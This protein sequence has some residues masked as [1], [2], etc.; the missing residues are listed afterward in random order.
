MH[1]VAIAWVF[2]VGLAA[3]V[4]ATSAQGSLLGALATLVFY[5]VV[6]LTVVL[7]V[8]GTP[9]R[10]RARARREASDRETADPDRGRH[11]TGDAVAPEREEP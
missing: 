9:L 11:A 2:V 1:I 5:G 10:R 3:L 4:E 7:Y 6:P 8:L